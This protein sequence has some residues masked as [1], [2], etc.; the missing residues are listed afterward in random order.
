M[1]EIP[2]IYADSANLSVCPHDVMMHFYQK[3]NTPNSAQPPTQVGCVR[4]S[5]E[6]AKLFAIIL[7]K[8]LKQH[9]DGQGC[10][11][12][13]HPQVVQAAGLSVAEDW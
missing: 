4:M 8:Y 6:C 10:P 1:S 12:K 11:I 7:K 5:L 13:I 2:D 3:A 9:E